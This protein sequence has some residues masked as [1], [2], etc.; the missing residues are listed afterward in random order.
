MRIA[1]FSRPAP[2]RSYPCLCRLAAYRYSRPRPSLT[3][4]PTV[5]TAAAGAGSS[6]AWPGST[7]RRDAAVE[8]GD[9]RLVR[10]RRSPSPPRRRSAGRAARSSASTGWTT[11]RARAST[12]APASRPRSARP[13]SPSTCSSRSRRRSS[14]PRRP[15]D[16]TRGRASS[17]AS[18]PDAC[19]SRGVTPLIEN[20][21]PILRMRTGGVFLSQLG[22]HWRDLLE[23][24]ERVP[25]LGFTID[26][27][28]AALFR[29][30]VAAYPALFG[31]A[32]DEELALERYVEELGPAAE[33]AHVSDAH[34]L[35]GEGLPYGAG[36]LDLDP[37][38]RRL[39]ELVP[40][41]VAEINEP[42]PARSAD[43]KRG[44][45]AI[46]RALAEAGGATA[47]SAATAAR[48]RLRLAERCIERRDPVPSVLE[49]QERF[50]G[51][52][53][54]DHRRRRL[55][56]ARAR[57]LPRRLPPRAHHAPGRPR[58]LADRRPPPARPGGA[59][60][61]LARPLRRPRGLAARDGARPRPA[62]R[63]LP[64][65]RVQARRL[66]RALPGG[67]RRHEPARELERPARRPSPPASRPS[68]SR[69]RTRPRSP[70]AS[71]AGRSGSWSS[72]ARTR[73][74][75]P[76]LSA[77]RSG[78]STCSRAPVPCP[79]SSCARPA[80]ASR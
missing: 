19:T 9:P 40:F 80:R 2:R 65:R 63:R 29:S 36:E 45:R 62:G 32:S 64:P 28:H 57:D 25:E 68:S 61:D 58:G 53:I 4:S 15:V 26:T 21:P 20:V 13:C 41:M 55:D 5:S 48:R 75:A 72:C 56:R 8:R 23:W 51:R 3:R 79:R 69:P 39:G 71:T 12:A 73:P 46:E 67:V 74:G 37:V 50:G 38:V 22:G 47:T 11:R 6:S 24:R 34:G 70:R 30:F 17:C 42:D 52:R 60:A 59:R 35:L 49:L 14:A 43:M 16:E 1:R 78:S 33:V 31:L 18:T 44:Y 7:S 10:A 54:A 77:P 66:G 27:S 76:A